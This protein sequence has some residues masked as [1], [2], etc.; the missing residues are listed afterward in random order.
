MWQDGCFFLGMDIDE[1]QSWHMRDCKERTDRSG[2]FTAER[3]EEDV[4]GKKGCTNLRGL[5]GYISG[6]MS[7]N[8]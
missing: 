3:R 8:P 6:R 7:Q 4:I 2:D 5:G 1:K